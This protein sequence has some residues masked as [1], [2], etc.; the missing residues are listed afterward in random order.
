MSVT[1]I[2]IAPSA[3]TDALFSISVREDTLDI[4]DFRTGSATRS[5]MF[6]VPE[7]RIGADSSPET[8][9]A[10]DWMQ[11]L[12]LILALEERFGLQLLPEGGSAVADDRFSS[13]ILPRQQERLANR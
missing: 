3:I 10:W 6:A 13:W 4:R 8:I 12:N 1:R 2:T 11:H 7:E 9:E 5:D